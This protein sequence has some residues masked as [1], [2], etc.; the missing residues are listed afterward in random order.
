M[1]LKRKIEKQF[2]DFNNFKADLDNPKLLS[3]KLCY[4]KLIKPPKK[5][6]NLTDKLKVRE[7][8]EKNIGES[9]LPKLLFISEYGD[10]IDASHIR[11]PQFVIKTNHDS[12]GV[13]LCRNPLSFNWERAKEKLSNHIVR[14]YYNLYYEPQYKD[15]DRKI[16]VEEYICDVSSETGIANEYKFYCF[17]GEP[18]LVKCEVV[19]NHKK[20]TSFFDVNWKRLHIKYNDNRNQVD[21]PQKPEKFDEMIEVVK[22]LSKGFKFIR[23]DLYQSSNKVYF[24]EVNFSPAGGYKVFSPLEFEREMGDNLIFDSKHW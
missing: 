24:G 16:F 1:T 20:R 10:F 19:Y 7:Y 15:I 18:I 22:D 11:L 3:E 5:I 14:D 4:R 13:I 2:F 23:I 21:N 9:Y 12:G 8:V 17:N 6:I